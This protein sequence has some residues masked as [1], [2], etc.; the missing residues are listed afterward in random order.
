MLYTLHLSLL[1]YCMPVCWQASYCFSC[2]LSCLVP[3]CFP[4][5]VHLLCQFLSQFSVLLFL[6]LLV[7]LSLWHLLVLFCLYLCFPFR[8][9]LFFRVFVGFVLL[10]F[11]CY[12]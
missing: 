1:A 4:L 2:N 8:I 12:S 7:L 9:L 11:C 10:P 6:G 3:R 5:M